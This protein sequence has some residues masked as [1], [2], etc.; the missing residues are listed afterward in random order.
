M[1]L[2]HQ[3]K[4]ILH[5]LSRYGKGLTLEKM[6]EYRRRGIDT[7]DA[8]AFT[9]YLISDFFNGIKGNTH[10]KRSLSASVSRSLRTLERKK[11]IFRNNKTMV[12]TEKGLLV[13]EKIRE[14]VLQIAEAEKPHILHIDKPRKKK[15][16]TEILSVGMMYLTTTDKLSRLTMEVR[17]MTKFLKQ[18]REEFK[19][20]FSVR[21]QRD[22]HK[23]LIV[24]KNTLGELADEIT[25]NQLSEKNNLN[26]MP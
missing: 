14:E 6:E 15:N 3:E 22:I 18:Y 19:P 16:D 17:T 13:A 1:R 12:V 2:G 4:T 26:S 5:H 24:L 25:T 20:S 7:E 21:H 23:R 11:L 8:T 9:E 10:N